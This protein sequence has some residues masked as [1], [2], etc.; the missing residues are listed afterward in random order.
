MYFVTYV[1]LCPSQSS[2]RK[3]HSCESSLIHM[4][5]DWYNYMDQNKIIGSTIVDLK[6]AFDILNHD[7][8]IK[9]LAL[10]GCGINTQKWFS[11]YLKDRSQKVVSGNTQSTSMNI[12][13]G[14]PQ[15]SI[16]GP[17]LFIIYMNDLTFD[18]DHVTT[19]MYADDTTFYAHANSQSDIQCLIQ[20]DMTKVEEWYRKN[21]MIQNT[22]MSSSMLLCNVQKDR[23]LDNN[24]L[25][26]LMGNHI[27]TSTQYADILGRKIDKNLKW[28]KHVNNIC[29]KLSRLLGLLNR[30]NVY[31][32]QEAK[33][34]FYN[35]YVV[36]VYSYCIALWSQCATVHLG[37]IF[38]L[39]KRF[40]RNI[41]NDFNSSSNVLFDRLKWLTVYE[42]VEYQTAIL[43]FKCIVLGNVPD[44]IKDMFSPAMQSRYNL[45]HQNVLMVT[46]PRTEMLR[47]SLSYIGP[48]IWNN[49]PT[50]LRDS[51]NIIS[52]KNGL[53]EYIISIKYVVM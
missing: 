28:D 43:M 5:N 50:H 17:L 29:S 47:K 21:R 1:L 40:L 25:Q 9:K 22:D 19:S 16:L 52:F 51:M 35:S 33:C 27:L 39:Q 8:I 2:F 7:L 45:R 31:L 23:Y 32:T 6:K 34:L 46:R 3:F 12:A 42:Y 36:P 14:I 13:Y 10:Y 49:L 38:R 48:E 44:Y 37:R 11:S 20:E 41:L 18:L 15:G 26:I 4:I 24:N 53:K 30:I